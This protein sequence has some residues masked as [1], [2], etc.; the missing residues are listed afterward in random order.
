[1]I[2]IL[3]DLET[4]GLQ[5]TSGAEITEA[6]LIKVEA[7]RP[8]DVY[9]SFF[10]IVR[11]IPRDIVEITGITN[12]MV[13]G[14]PSIASHA[15]LIKSFIGR[16]PILAYNSNFEQSFMTHYGLVEPNHPFL[17][18]HPWVREM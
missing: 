11:G 1:M 13:H 4:T 12:D 16:A 9:H 3:A 15:S 5:P 10:S 18:L 2:Y 6:G 14:F 7:Y 17:D 8:F